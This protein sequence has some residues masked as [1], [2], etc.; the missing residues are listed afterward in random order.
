[1]YSTRST[2]PEAGRQWPSNPAEEGFEEPPS[3]EATIPEILDLQAGQLGS[4]P[5]PDLCTPQ[6]N[7]QLRLIRGRGD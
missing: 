7:K 2:F 5:L 3:E 6:V 4:N 1:M